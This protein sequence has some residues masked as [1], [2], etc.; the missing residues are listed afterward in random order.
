M[1]R[2]GFLCYAH[3]GGAS[4][5]RR[6]VGEL[7]KHLN[8]LEPKHEHHAWSDQDIRDGADW[9]AE[10]RQALDQAAYAV[11]FINA[12]FFNSAFVQQVEL[13]A[14]LGAAQR[15]GLLLLALRVG[16]CV[17]PDWIARIQFSNHDDKPLSALLPHA[18]DQIYTAVAERVE[19]H[20]SGTGAQ[21]QSV[22]LMGVAPALKVSEAPRVL[23]EA[24]PDA[25]AGQGLDLADALSRHVAEKL[26]D[27]RE[28]F[29][30]GERKAAQD[31]LQALLD[32]PEWPALNPALQGRMLRT[33]AM[34][35]LVVQDD[36]DGAKELALRAQRCDPDGDGQVLAAHIAL[37]SQDSDGALRLLEAPR[38]L[39]ARHLKAAM[40]IE[41]GHAAAALKALEL[42]P[43]EA[44]TDA[45]PNTE[46][47][48]LR[49]LALLTLRRLPDAADAIA[50]AKAMSPGWLAVRSVS[51]II[52]FWQACTPAAL[53]VSD[54]P[55]WPMPFSRA[56]VRKDAGARERLEEAAQALSGVASDLR[57]GSREWGHWQTWRLIC[58]LAA[59][60]PADEVSA[61]ASRLLSGEGD[62]HLW[63]LVWALHFHLDFDRGELKRRLRGA[64]SDDED[65][66][67]QR[68]LW[69]EMALADG[70]VSDVL[71]D[72][73]SLQPALAATG[74]LDI[75]H[76]WQVLALASAGQMEEARGVA[77]AIA[78]DRVRLRLNL[79]IV[80][81]LERTTPGSLVAALDALLASDPAPDIL[82]EACEAHAEAGDWSFVAE[83]AD[84][85]LAAIPTP[86]TVRLLVTAAWNMGEYGRCLKALDDQRHL[87]PNGRLPT[88]LAVLRV[89]CQRALGE[90]SQAAREARLLLD[91]DPSPEHWAELLNAQLETADRTGILESLR[92]LMLIDGADGELLLKGAHIALQLDRGLAVALWRQ[93]VAKGSERVDSYVF[94]ILL[95]STF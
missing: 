59:G 79:Q 44:A 85:L 46:T 20:L 82:A 56:F 80:R 65:F 71:G 49:A 2:N 43:G 4:P 10:V 89:R 35:R 77:D 28:R 33:A 47:W 64:T 90:A 11:L 34:Y 83:H 58:L 38:S 57:E 5:S 69:V 39:E 78:D 70:E 86:T 14:L 21:P 68:S 50:Q 6:F 45:K 41:E 55:L 76:Q 18:R 3:N 48:R 54:K 67:I 19:E 53:A 92:R 75:L 74:Q 32:A 17:L 61:L 16:Y 40:L 30:G 7:Q 84:E 60:D 88:D 81:A 13:P 37:R 42:T 12:D 27:L 51:A 23:L 73:A 36:V 95:G 31:A 24:S 94:G 93:A 62:L 25:A 8:P 63:P 87:Y 22:R 15:D 52:M 72:L 26:E 29:R 66:L 91:Q 1:R 9:P